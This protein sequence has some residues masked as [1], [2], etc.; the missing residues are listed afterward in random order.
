MKIKEITIRTSYSR[1]IS[2]NKDLITRLEN[3]DVVKI[4]NMETKVV[5]AHEDPD[6]LISRIREIYMNNPHVK[7]LVIPFTPGNNYSPPPPPPKVV[8]RKTKR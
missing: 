1:T 4:V 8:L 2:G 5:L 3:V 7:I 6:V